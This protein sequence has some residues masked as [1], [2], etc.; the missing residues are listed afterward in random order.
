MKLT[1]IDYD[2]IFLNCSLPLV[3][4]M[5]SVCTRDISCFSSIVWFSVYSRDEITVIRVV[6][7]VRRQGVAWQNL[8]FKSVHSGTQK[9]K[10]FNTSTSDAVKQVA[11]IIVCG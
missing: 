3:K 2:F 11:R 1:Q 6:V 8:P 9:F 10:S 5:I 7:R 4:V